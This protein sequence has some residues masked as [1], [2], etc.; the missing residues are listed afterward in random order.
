MRNETTKRRLR[1]LLGFLVA[2]G[3]PGLLVTL[4]LGILGSD[5]TLVSGMLTFLAYILALVIGVPAYMYAKARGLAAL[6]KATRLAANIGLAAYV[7][8]AGF[9]TLSGAL[10]SPFNAVM[11]FLASLLI[12]VVPVLYGTCALWLFRRIALR[13]LAP[14]FGP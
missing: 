10:A 13:D 6:K 1:V 8:I 4:V 12:V 11:T 3:L 2:P 5:L 7:L 14:R 9:V